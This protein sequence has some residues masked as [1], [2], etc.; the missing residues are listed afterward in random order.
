MDKDMAHLVAITMANLPT[1]C[2]AP[3]DDMILVAMQKAVAK[4]YRMSKQILSS[5]S[6]V[7]GALDKFQHVMADL[8]YDKVNA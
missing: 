1:G 8:V 6:K 2:V 5:Q 3:T 7:G 4:E